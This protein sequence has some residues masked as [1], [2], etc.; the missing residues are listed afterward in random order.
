MLKEFI[1]QF[2]HFEKK[3]PGII[4][5]SVHF[6]FGN[7]T[8][9]I[10][11]AS[12]VHGN[13]VGS[14]PAVLKVIQKLDSHEIKY[15]GKISF[16]LGNKQ[17][18][19]ENKRFLKDDLNRSF[20]NFNHLNNSPEKQRANEIKKIL[21]IADVFLDFH[22]TTMPCHDPFYIFAMHLQ[23]Y[24]WARAIGNSK[25]FVTRKKNK[26]YSREGICSDEYMRS[27]DKPGITLE[28]GE[29]GFNLNSELTCLRAIKKSLWIMDQIQLRKKTLNSLAHKNSDFKFLSIKY[30][31]KFFNHKMYLFKDFFNLQKIE[32]NKKMGCYEND[33]FFYSPFEGY[34]LFPQYPARDENEFII[35]PLPT[36]IYALATEIKKF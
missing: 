10:A 1:R 28:L 15:G 13:E 17:A 32:K 30:S 7:H 31:E 21:N 9:H 3:H 18:C 4:P 16:I 8:G 23:S 5:D 33:N 12:V 25:I 36:Y 20:G 2:E 29:Q 35:D 26:P 11:I 34:L 19:F 14:I 6:D 22:Q 27:L 24:L